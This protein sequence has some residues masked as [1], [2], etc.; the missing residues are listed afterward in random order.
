MEIT[1]V[2]GLPAKWDMYVNAR[3]EIFEPIVIGL[4]FNI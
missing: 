1:V 3:Q 2:A 4:V